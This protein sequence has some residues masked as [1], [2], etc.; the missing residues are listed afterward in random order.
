MQKVFKSVALLSALLMLACGGGNGGDDRSSLPE[1]TAQRY[2]DQVFAQTS[3]TR[4][5][6]YAQVPRLQG[7][8]TLF[9]DIYQPRN[10]ANRNRPV[11]ILAHGGGFTSGNRQDV[12]FIA[13]NFA[14]RGYVAATIDYRFFEVF[15]TQNDEA[16]IAI[17]EAVHDMKA[18]IRHLRVST[19]N[20]NPYGI[21][22]EIGRAHV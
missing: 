3:V 18:A 13:E 7:A 19:S 17:I 11:L 22:S 14:R 15:P 12:A 8:Q 5:V 2:V 10:D 6:A 21:D 1:P 9:M 20:G 16:D 4:N